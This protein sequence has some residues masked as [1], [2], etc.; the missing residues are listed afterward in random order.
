MGEILNNIRICNYT[1]APFFTEFLHL[2]DTAGPNMI[3]VARKKIILAEN[4]VMQVL[5]KKFPNH[6][7]GN[8]VMENHVR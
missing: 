5:Y 1:T 8:H 6:V 2:K 4:H 3:F 7:M